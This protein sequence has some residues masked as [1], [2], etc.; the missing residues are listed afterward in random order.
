MLE[1]PSRI[2]GRTVSA[3]GAGGGA[4]SLKGETA[5]LLSELRSKHESWLPDLMKSELG[6]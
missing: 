1:L 2:V 3:D 5:L 4:I 6:A